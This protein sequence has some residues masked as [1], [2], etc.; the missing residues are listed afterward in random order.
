[1]LE[2]CV[3]MEKRSVW[4]QKCLLWGALA[5][6]VHSVWALSLRLDAMYKPLKMF[7]DMA[8]GEHIPF[9]TAMGYFDWSILD[10]PLRLA[11]SLVLGLMAL[12]LRK[13]PGAAWFLMPASVLMGFAGVSAMDLPVALPWNF[14]SLL[15]LGLVALGSLGQLFAGRGTPR[16]AALESAPRMTDAPRLQRL[17]EG[18]AFRKRADM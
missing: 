1:M 15:P 11:A 8:F 9:S 13:R 12:L 5:L 7:F 18:S 16:R 6:I 3:I 17:R 10:V 2:V 4:G 14:V